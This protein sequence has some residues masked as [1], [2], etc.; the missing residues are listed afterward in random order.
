MENFIDKLLIS[1]INHMKTDTWE[2]PEHWDVP[3]KRR[4]LQ[5]CLTYAEN[6]EFYE[7]CAIIRDVEKELDK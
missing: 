5:Q 6:N 7:Q 1:S 2:W 3:R 4:F